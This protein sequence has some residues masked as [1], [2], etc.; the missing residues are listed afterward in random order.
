MRLLTGISFGLGV[1]W[2]AFPFLDDAFP[3]K[4]PPVTGK[5]LPPQLN[6]YGMFQSEEIH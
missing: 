1:V 6:V 4:V 5:A 3:H 2:F